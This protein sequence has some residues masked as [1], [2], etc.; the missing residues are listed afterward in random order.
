[1]VFLSSSSTSTQKI[2]SIKNTFFVKIGT[3]IVSIY[4]VQPGQD[5]SV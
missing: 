3:V 5:L 2:Y 4:L 1:M